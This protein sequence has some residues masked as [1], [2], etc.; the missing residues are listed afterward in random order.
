MKRAKI[1]ILCIL[2]CVA[3]IVTVA[4]AATSS[5]GSSSDPLVTL[6]YLD[7]VY[8]PEMIDRMDTMVEEESKELTE[9]FDEAIL[10]V[11]AGGDTSSSSF[12]VVTLSRGQT[13]VGDVGCEVMLR[14]GSATCG[15]DSSTG[16]IDETDGTVLGDGGALVTNHLYMVTISTRS[17]KA[18]ADTVKVLA[19]GPYTIEG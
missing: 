1:K 17:V 10:S 15:S 3:L 16:L 6:S 19:R 13:L 14:I 5:A 18:T 2:L 12:V 7:D 11:P 4:Y 8:T 9:L